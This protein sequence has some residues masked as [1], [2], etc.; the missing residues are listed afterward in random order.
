MLPTRDELQHYKSLSLKLYDV[1][2]I[3]GVTTEVRDTVKEMA[4]VREVLENMGLVPD[5]PY[6]VYSFGSSCEGTFTLGLGFDI[7]MVYVDIMPVD[8]NIVNSKHPRVL[9]VPENQTGY[10]KLQLL[11][12]GRPIF[13]D[14][15]NVTTS[16]LYCYKVDKNNRVC[17]IE[18]VEDGPLAGVHKQVPAFHFSGDGCQ[19]PRDTVYAL[20]CETWPECA[21]EWLIR[22]RK[23]D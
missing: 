1:M 8:T 20:K 12:E 5:F 23:V 9:L 19:L 13:N 3:I 7:D 10:A 2:K 21:S 15:S 14:C 11:S 6:S 17:K 18:K 16:Q 4:L 22:Q